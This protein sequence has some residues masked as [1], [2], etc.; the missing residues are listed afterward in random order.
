[1][2]GRPW[3]DIRATGNLAAFFGISALNGE[4]VGH[5]KDDSD[6]SDIPDRHGVDKASPANEADWNSHRLATRLATGW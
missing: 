4:I 2:R 6:L 5:V 3:L 1:M